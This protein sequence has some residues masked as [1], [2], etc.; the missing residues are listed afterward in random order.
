MPGLIELKVGDY[1]LQPGQAWHD[2]A[3]L[4]VILAVVLTRE[5]IPQ[6][7]QSGTREH[8]DAIEKSQRLNIQTILL[9]N[10]YK[11]LVKATDCAD[12]KEAALADFVED[13]LA[14]LQVLGNYC[15][16]HKGRLTDTMPLG[17][18]LK[19]GKLSRIF[20][21]GVLILICEQRYQRGDAV[22]IGAAIQY[23]CDTYK[24]GPLWISNTNQ[25]PK[26][27]TEMKPVAHFCAALVRLLLE[28]GGLQADHNAFNVWRRKMGRFLELA[29]HYEGIVARERMTSRAVYD[30]HRGGRGRSLHKPLLDEKMI[31]RLPPFKPTSAIKAVEALPT[32]GRKTR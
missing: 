9:L 30:R 27:W 20:T 21:I 15:R 25:T 29:T 5:Y 17:Y 8:K 13:R 3:I 28:N 12:D 22:L 31:W 23:I 6:G 7:R 14:L 10:V 26:L 16:A 4:A 18:Y 24:T 2:R 32:V 19:E 1:Q 11:Q